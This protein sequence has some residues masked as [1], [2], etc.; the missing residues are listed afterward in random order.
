[1]LGSAA[2]ADDAVQETM[3]RAWRAL[4]QFDGR[5]SLRTWRPPTEPGGCHKPWALIVLEIEG[6]HIAT[7]NYFLDTAALFPRFGL[8]AEL[9]PWR[10]LFRIFSARPMIPEPPRR[11]CIEPCPWRHT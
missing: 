2:E 6:D 7:M 3:L 9:C 10:E 5:A 11:P 1:M 4:G 8:P